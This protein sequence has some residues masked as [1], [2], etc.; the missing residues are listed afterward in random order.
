MKGVKTGVCLAMMGLV[1]FSAQAQA[2]NTMSSLTIN[3]TIT[4]ANPSSCG[5]NTLTSSGSTAFVNPTINKTGSVSTTPTSYQS[6]ALGTGA[7]GLPVYCTTPFTVSADGGLASP[8][9]YANAAVSRYLYA[10][11]VTTASKFAYNLV[12]GTAQPSSSVGSTPGSNAGT[13]KNSVT[14]GC[15]ASPTMSAAANTVYI[16]WGIY[17]D[18]PT[19]WGN[20]ASTTTYTDTPLLAGTVLVSPIILELTA[21][22]SSG[23]VTLK[24]ASDDPAKI[25]L[26]VMKWSMVNGED[27]LE[28]ATDV[29]VSPP[30]VTVMPSAP[31]TARVVRL[32]TTPLQGEENYRLVIDEILVNPQTGVRKVQF[33]FAVRQSMPV[34]FRKANF[35]PINIVWK[36]VRDGNKL[37]LQGQNNGDEH[38]RLESLAVKDSAGKAVLTTTGLSGYILGHS[39][40]TWEL[41]RVPAGVNLNAPLSVSA[42]TQDK[43]RINAVTHFIAPA[44]AEQKQAVLHLDV[45]INGT[46]TDRIG[47]FV[48]FNGAEIGATRNDLEEIGLHVSAGRSPTDIVMLGSIPQLKYDYSEP[49]QRISFTVPENLRAARVYDL[50]GAPTVRMKGQ[51]SWG[52]LV[53]YDLSGA[54]G[55]G[56]GFRNF[57]YDGSTLSLDG[58]FFS[59]FGTVEQTAYAT[60]SSGGGSNIYRLNTTFEH[61]D[62]DRAITY[63]AGDITTMGL[64]WTRS[65]RLG[66]VQAFNNFTLRSD[67][68]QGVMPSLRGTAMVPSTVDVYINN[69]K[70]LSQDVNAGPFSLSNIPQ[71]TGAGNAELVIRDASGNETKTIVP[72]YT[73]PTL[74]RPGLTDWSFETGL[75]RLSFGAGDDIYVLTPVATATLRRGITDSLTAQFHAEGGT[76]IVNGSAGAAINAANRGIL[77]LAASASTSDYGTGFQGYVSFDTTLAGLT[78]GIGSQRAFGEYYDVAAVTA[79]MKLLSASQLNSSY[80]YIG[81]LSQAVLT[82]TSV[83]SLSSYFSSRPSRA[84]DHVTIGIPV[85]FDHS[86]N[87]GL[88]LINSHDYSGIRSRIVQASLSRSFPFNISAFATAYRDFGTTKSMGIF[89][90]LSMPLGDYANVSL[91]SSRSGHS[92]SLSADA[93]IHQGPNAGNF[94]WQIHD[95]ETGKLNV[96]YRGAQVAYRTNYGTVQATAGGSSTSASGALELRGSVATMGG[97]VVAGNWIDDGFAIVK[98]GAPDIEVSY[99]NQ[100]VGKTDWRG[101]LLIPSLRSYEMNRISINPATLPVDSQFDRVSD[102]VAPADHGGVLVN[103]ALRDGSQTALVSFVRPDGSFIPAGTRGRI[104]GG[105]EFFVGYDGMAYITGLNR[106]NIANFELDNGLCRASFDFAPKKGTQIHIGPVKCQ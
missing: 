57:T 21:P 95:S 31:Y 98:T 44:S 10:G 19:G 96:G 7:F 51:S 32:A 30:F 82:G 53:N 35:A 29:V 91:N 55:S 37:M 97:Q 38:A 50:G 59:P 73:A 76:K 18:A 64:P 48:Q 3:L 78:I 17:I 2:G 71:V 86:T 63:R 103:F 11:G 74:L 88:S 77:G 79:N 67:Q 70:S 104:D 34:F 46:S 12:L 13:N 27:R 80:G 22:V 47:T 1:G 8:G 62:Q 42:T 89:A 87:L 36:L 23:T 84:N 75:P 4:N 28:P 33:N 102:V 66:G 56:V 58:K 61:S 92:T 69:I 65:V 24:S 93:S 16:P 101:S 54:G 39:S 6:P 60:S 99:E 43:G 83:T 41:S 85:P 94:S 9:T 25:Q 45:Y 68:I 26:R 100:P 49:L 15:Y 52:A 20:P 90:G 81:S 106:Q 40:K 105:E 5:I 14:S 72:F